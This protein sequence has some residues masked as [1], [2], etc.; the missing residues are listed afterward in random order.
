MDAPPNR[1][2]M[3]PHCPTPDPGQRASWVNFAKL[4]QAQ[5]ELLDWASLADESAFDY[6]YLR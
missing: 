4:Q 5:R 1:P 2:L 3:T 6:A